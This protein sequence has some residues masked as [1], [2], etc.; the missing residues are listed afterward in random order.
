MNSKPTIRDVARDA[1][2]LPLRRRAELVA[3]SAHRVRDPA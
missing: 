2:P 1:H 3:E